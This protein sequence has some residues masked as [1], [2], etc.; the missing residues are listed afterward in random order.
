MIDKKSLRFGGVFF[1]FNKVK[2]KIGKFHCSIVSLPFEICVNIT[3][4]KNSLY[5]KK[6]SKFAFHFGKNIV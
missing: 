2:P 6:I 4:L 5:R 3:K 1:W